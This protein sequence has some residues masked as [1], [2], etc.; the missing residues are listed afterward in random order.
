MAWRRDSSRRA[1]QEATHSHFRRRS[2]AE[3]FVEPTAWRLL[4]AWD[5]R[6]LRVGDRSGRDTHVV[7]GRQGFGNAIGRFAFDEA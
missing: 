7:V 4:L 2:T 5:G 3:Y 1:S 6:E